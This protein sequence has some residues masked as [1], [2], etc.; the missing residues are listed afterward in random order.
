MVIYG[1]E[2][3]LSDIYGMNLPYLWY[4]PATKSALSLS[5]IKTKVFKTNYIWKRLRRN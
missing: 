1:K 4:L 3:E 2:E 5:Y